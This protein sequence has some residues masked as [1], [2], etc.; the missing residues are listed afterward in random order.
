M[1]KV[2]VELKEPHV[3]KNP[4]QIATTFRNSLYLI[5]PRNPRKL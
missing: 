2:G 4:T 3:E 1:D 5:S